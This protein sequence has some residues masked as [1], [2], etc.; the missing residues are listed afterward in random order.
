MPLPVFMLTR[1]QSWGSFSAEVLIASWRSHEK[2][3]CLGNL[4]TST[5]F[6]RMPYSSPFS[7]GCQNI[8]WECRIIKEALLPSPICHRWDICTSQAAR[9]AHEDTAA[10]ITGLPA[11]PPSPEMLGTSSLTVSGIACSK[12][13]NP[14][15][16][17]QTELT[18]GELVGWTFPNLSPL[19]PRRTDW[20][21]QIHVS[22]R[23]CPTPTGSFQKKL[24]FDVIQIPSFPLKRFVWKNNIFFKTLQKWNKIILYSGVFFMINEVLTMI[25]ISVSDLQTGHY[26]WSS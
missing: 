18:A 22:S 12:A 9:A 14:W 23:G 19:V 24:V 10:D 8:P 7:P 4:L 5:G 15:S 21:E 6:Q 17:S 3:L 25:A 1:A 20:W 26:S 11:Q 13:T 2:E 16:A